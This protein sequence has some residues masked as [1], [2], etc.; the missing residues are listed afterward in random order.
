MC[1][2]TNIKKWKNLYVALLYKVNDTKLEID[3]SHSSNQKQQP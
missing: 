1:S 3:I 2:T